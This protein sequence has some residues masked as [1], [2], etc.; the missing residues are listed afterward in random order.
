MQSSD[1][2][3]ESRVMFDVPEI[4]GAEL[5]EMEYWDEY[6]LQQTNLEVRKMSTERKINT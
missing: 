4:F 2:A 5:K 6:I 1:Y 3:K